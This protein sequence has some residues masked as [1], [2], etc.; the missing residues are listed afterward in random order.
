[1][2]KFALALDLKENEDLIAEYEAWHK[3]VP[4]EIK[5]SIFDSGIQSM[6]IYRLGN[7]LFMTIET[8]DDFSFERKASLDQSNPH[9]QEWER[10]MWKFQQPL[11]TAKEGEKWI[12]MNKI[13]ELNNKDFLHGSSTAK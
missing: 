12:H 6:E 13:F 8:N 9:V 2:K 5:K 1:M 3:K 10:L 11:P 4:S 7:R